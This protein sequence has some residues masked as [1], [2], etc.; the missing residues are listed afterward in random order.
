MNVEF[1]KDSTISSNKKHPIVYK[2]IS[3]YFRNTD[4]SKLKLKGDLIIAAKQKKL[5]R[6]IIEFWKI[7]SL[8]SPLDYKIADIFKNTAQNKLKRK[9]F[10]AIVWYWIKSRDKKL[11]KQLNKAKDEI[12]ELKTKISKF[13]NEKLE[14]LLQKI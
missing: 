9:V 11:N 8:A 5:K 7:Y 4:E 3:Q 10:H 13:D 2:R 14:A 1:R 6:N 12:L